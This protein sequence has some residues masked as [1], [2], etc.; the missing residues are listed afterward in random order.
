MYRIEPNSLFVGGRLRKFELF[1]D[2]R[3]WPNCR[4]MLAID[5][6]CMRIYKRIDAGQ[7]IVSNRRQ[8]NSG[9]TC[10]VFYSSCT[11]NVKKHVYHRHCGVGWPAMVIKCNR[12]CGAGWP[13][14]G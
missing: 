2:A 14:K 7:I 10:S 1:K 3:I 5:G 13:G 11:L 9:N 6:G 4:W 12:Y 8:W